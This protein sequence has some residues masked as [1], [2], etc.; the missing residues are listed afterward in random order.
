VSFRVA[1]TDKAK[2]ALK[3]L[4]KASP[5]RLREYRRAMAQIAEKPYSFGKPVD[6][7]NDKRRAA[8]AGTVTEFWISQRVLTVT[9]VTIIHTD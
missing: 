8:V 6:R 3:A 7:I 4:E 1:Y 2:A 5:D 9:V